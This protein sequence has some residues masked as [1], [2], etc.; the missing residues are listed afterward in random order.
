MT[1]VRL[2]RRT[3]NAIPV[4]PKAL[5]PLR[6]APCAML[7][8]LSRAPIADPTPSQLI[9]YPLYQLLN[10]C[11]SAPARESARMGSILS[12]VMRAKWR[13]FPLTNF[14]S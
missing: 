14:R 1:D 6:H 2:A 7:H 3:P 12:S 11:Y 4:I 5:Y 9:T 13:I 8:A 10:F